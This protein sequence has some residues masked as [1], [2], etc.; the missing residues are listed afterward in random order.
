MSITRNDCL[1]RDAKDAFAAKRDLFSL[2]KGVIYLDGNSLGALPKNVS[3][4]VTAAVEQQWGETLVKSWNEHGWFHLPQK[5]GNRLARLIGA[6]PDSVTVGDSISVNLFKILSAAVVHKRDRKIILT[7]SGNF[8]SDIYVAQG[9]TQ[10]LANG[11]EVKVVDP[12]EV[13]AAINDKVAVVMIT[14]VD[15]RT[16]R[17]H[18]MKALTKM[19]HASGA[20]M[21][22]D[23][24]HSAGAMPV[25]LTGGDA[26]FAVGCTYKYLNGGPGAP[27]FVYVKPTLQNQV[28]PALVGW[29]GHAKPFEFDLDFVPAHGIIRQQCGTQPILS[30]TALDAAL[31]AWDD[32]DMEELHGKSKALCQ[33]LIDLVEE[34]CASHGI[35]AAGPRDLDKRGSHVSFNCAEGYAVMQALIADGVVGDFRAPD[36]IRFGVAPLYTR[37][38]DIWDAAA[39]LARVLDEKLWDKPEFMA[40]KA[41]T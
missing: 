10:F 7:D 18:D 17:R 32:V 26:D 37:F 31:D 41:V 8:P 33:L 11:Y 2:P 22:W 15:Y 28:Q 36:I 3:K 35:K 21:I 14:E 24:A 13:A 19:A 5:I 1:G 23:L 39:I 20:L 27:A 30:M 16:A 29:W 9:L 34:S 40:K 38:A 4:R 6:E 25:D 12:E